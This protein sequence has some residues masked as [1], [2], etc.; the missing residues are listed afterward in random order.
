MRE[1]RVTTPGC[2]FDIN[3]VREPNPRRKGL[4]ATVTEWKALREE[5]RERAE[6]KDPNSA[7]QNLPEEEILSAFDIISA[8]K[9]PPNLLD[10]SQIGVVK[11]FKVPF[12][13]CFSTDFC[14]LSSTLHCL[15]EDMLY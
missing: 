5:R 1:M 6:M 2:F 8:G 12:I 11:F 10:K 9:S 4:P 15:I 7:H 3:Q 14:L 13:K